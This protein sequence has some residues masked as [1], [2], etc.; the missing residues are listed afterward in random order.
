MDM[1][2][3]YFGV[4]WKLLLVEIIIGI[5]EVKKIAKLRTIDILNKCSNKS[6]L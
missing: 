5:G 1:K 2:L 4:L 6:K 3:M